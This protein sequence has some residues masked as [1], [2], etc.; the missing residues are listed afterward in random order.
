MDVREEVGRAARA[1]RLVLSPQEEERFA[2]EITAILDAFCTL[3]EVNVDGV[4][5]SFHPIKAKT[6]L[7][8]DEPRVYEWDPFANSLPEN[9]LR[10]R[11]LFIGPKVLGE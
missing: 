8:A 1:A 11:R 3:N 6:E 10:E 7:R 4:E 9:V 2:V 5:P